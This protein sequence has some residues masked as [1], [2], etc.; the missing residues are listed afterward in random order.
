MLSKLRRHSD[1]VVAQLSEIPTDLNLS[2]TE[3]VRKLITEN[4][5]DPVR[6]SD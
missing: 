1:K 3:V 2:R 4:Q 6:M 5:I